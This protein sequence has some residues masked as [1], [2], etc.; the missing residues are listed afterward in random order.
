M[1][2]LSAAFIL[3][4]SLGLFARTQALYA[5]P[6]LEVSLSDE[7]I[8]LSKTATLEIQVKWPK[9]E[10][11]YSM[12]LPS[13]SLK[14]LTLLRQ[15]ESQE[16]FRL[17]NTDWIRKTFSFELKPLEKGEGRV[18]GFKLPYIDPAQQKGGALTVE[19][20][21]LKITQD[22]IPLK[23]I[24]TFAAIPAGLFALGGVFFMAIRR[25]RP[26]SSPELEAGITPLHL[27]L[28]NLLASAGNA[29]EER[30]RI[31][32][33]EL[34]RVTAQTYQLGS[35]AQTERE[36]IEAIQKQGRLREETD[37]LE[38][39]LSRTYEIKFAAK[40]ASDIELSRLEEDV[41]RF[42]QLKSTE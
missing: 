28:K 5:K 8:P 33:N 26:G 3:T 37:D 36:L 25:K 38:R 23:K 1:L 4:L 14:N 20:K 29:R 2:Q 22:P 21:R 16:S 18:E 19:E 30:L 35:A 7:Q 40:S 13:L 32:S 11:D 41:I 24:L 34:R 27:R 15:G 6:N 12:T 9:D 42:I 39:L 31:L 17:S 10:A